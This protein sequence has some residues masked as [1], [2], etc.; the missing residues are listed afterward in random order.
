M[1]DQAINPDA[2]CKTENSFRGPLVHFYETGEF[3]ILDAT[4]LNAVSGALGAAGV[5]ASCF[6]QGGINADC[7]WGIGAY[8]AYCVASQWG[9]NDVCQGSGGSI[10]NL[11][12]LTGGLWTR[13]GA[14]QVCDGAYNASSNTACVH[15]AGDN[16]AACLMNPS[17]Y[18]NTPCY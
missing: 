17:C 13:D 14:N 6:K 16:N 10:G 18:T 3:E 7:Q 5:N 2:N 15:S 4:V 9:Q 12:C 1:H 8:N 11:V